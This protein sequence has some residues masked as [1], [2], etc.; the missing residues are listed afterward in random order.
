MSI[1]NVELTDIN[2]INDTNTNINTNTD[3]V[4]EVVEE[5]LYDDTIDGDTYRNLFDVF[6]LHYN[7]DISKGRNVNMLSDI[8]A[9]NPTET[10]HIMEKFYSMLIE[11]SNFD[12]EELSVC[13]YNLAIE[14]NYP[15]K[16]I[17]TDNSYDNTNPKYVSMSKLS[18]YTY[19]ESQYKVNNKED[20]DK[21]MN[22][23]ITT[24]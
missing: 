10:N 7:R 8:N 12:D 22:C 23:Y 13:E 6:T 16:Y 5:T 24:V 20:V 18:L 11:S 4:T 1:S 9:H 15:F 2:D 3:D 17:L 14:R 19:I 21:I